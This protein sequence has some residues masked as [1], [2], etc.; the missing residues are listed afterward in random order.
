MHTT[1]S[2]SVRHFRRCIKDNPDELFLRRL[3]D[4]MNA[5][6]KELTRAEREDYEDDDESDDTNGEDIAIEENM[7]KEISSSTIENLEKS[8]IKMKM[9]QDEVT[10]RSSN[11]SL[12]G[13]EDAE[14]AG[15]KSQQVNNY[16]I[17]SV[18]I[19]VKL[20]LLTFAWICM[21]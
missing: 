19:Q 15:T 14:S 7:D 2:G 8:E 1:S 6:R 10:D 11:A 4:I 9:L 20:L 13:D 16:S 18:T 3:Y 12:L 5:T 21:Q 17:R